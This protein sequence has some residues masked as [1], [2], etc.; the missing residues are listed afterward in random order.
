MRILLTGATSQL[1]HA[2]LPL[3]ANEGAEVIAL[4][5]DPRSTPVNQIEWVQGVLPDAMP[6]LSRLDAIVSFGPLDGLAE[7]LSAKSDAPTPIVVAA[8]SMSAVSKRDSGVSED[9]AVAE[10]LLRGEAALQRECERLGMRWTILRPTMIYGVGLD[11]NLTP[12]ARR[13]L[14]SRMFP[15]PPGS[16][17][18]QPV[19]AQDVAQ[20]ALSA[21]RNEAASSRIIELGGGERLRVDEMFRRVRAS[22]ERSTF[23]LAVPSA[24]LPLAARLLPR[25][26]GA[27]SRLD[28]DLVAD[29]TVAIDVLGVQPRPFRP[30]MAT[31]QVQS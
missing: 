24:A 16:G 20:A 10:R 1:G 29:N 26:R 7:W 18:R 14:R 31:W 17:L 3:L 28:Q 22:L 27:L 15:I 8:S 21:V 5:R 13:A 19:H 9:R 30:T 2:A 4:S 6:D 23:P 25:L 11:R 12:V